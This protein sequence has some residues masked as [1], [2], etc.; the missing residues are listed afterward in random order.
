MTIDV[1]IPVAG[2]SKFIEQAISSASSQGGDFKLHVIENNIGDVEYSS[3]LRRLAAEHGANYTFFEPRLPIAASWQRCTSVGDSEW[4]TFLHDDDVWP[5]HHVASCA[6]LLNQLDML[7]VP[8]RFFQGDLGAVPVREDGTLRIPGSREQLL[9]EMLN[10]YNHASSTF[11]RRNLGLRFPAELN[12]AL[13]QYAFRQCVADNPGIR[14]GWLATTVAVPIRQHPNQFTWSGVLDLGAKENAISYRHFLARAAQE[15]LDIDR[16]SK[17][18]A[19][20]YTVDILT[21]IFSSVVWCS[22]FPYSTRLLFKTAKKKGAPR[23]VPLSLA[24]SLL[25]GWI[26]AL[27]S[28]YVR[29]R[30]RNKPLPVKL[31]VAPQ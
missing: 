30:L 5:I 20:V 21:R 27:K 31:P 3:Y 6:P 14:V 18:L 11:F 22:L 10:S 16:M 15:N 26:W 2:R 28:A 7:F 9:A 12:M 13:D 29:Y 19:N 23:V 25:Q 24:R 17:H 8:Y 1:L 4:I